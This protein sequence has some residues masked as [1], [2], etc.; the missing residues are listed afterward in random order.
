MRMEL[1]L[2]VKGVL[3]QLMS[4]IFSWAKLEILAMCVGVDLKVVEQ[5][6]D[7]QKMGKKSVARYIVQHLSMD[8][9]D[10]A[11]RTVFKMSNRFEK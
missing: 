10:L 6:I 11:I 2:E 4:E 8:R 5:Q 3:A 1:S 7:Q 9:E